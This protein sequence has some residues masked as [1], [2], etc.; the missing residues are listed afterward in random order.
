MRFFTA[1]RD[2]LDLFLP[3]CYVLYFPAVLI[4]GLWLPKYAPSFI[5]FAYFLPVVIFNG[6][7]NMVGNTYMLVLRKEG[8]LLGVNAVTVAFS[9]LGALLGTYVFHS[10][11]VII[12]FSVVALMLRSVYVERYLAK[13]FK[14]SNSRLFFGA[15]VVTVVFLAASI[16]LG[17]LFAF[18]VTVVAYFAYV[19]L[20]RKEAAVLL[21]QVKALF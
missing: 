15:L 19:F 3:F 12:A 20:C 7:M 6:K 2:A 1:S 21:G 8:M 18:V 4:L 16:A 17:S 9:G 14:V 10:I 5:Y 13:N 11:E